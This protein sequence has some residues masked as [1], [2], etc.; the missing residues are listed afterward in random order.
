MGRGKGSVGEAQER[1]SYLPDNHL[2]LGESLVF[3]PKGLYSPL[4]LRVGQR[5]AKV[6]VGGGGAVL[7][8]FTLGQMDLSL[9][10]FRS[11]T[12]CCPSLLSWQVIW[13][14]SEL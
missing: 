13:P 7:E 6:C 4:I 11:H 8:E 3:Q 10:G 5:C 14:S 2:S 12:S 1:G 9:V